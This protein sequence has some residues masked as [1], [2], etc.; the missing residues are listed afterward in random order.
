MKTNKLKLSCLFLLISL[1]FALSNNTTTPSLNQF[2]EIS[3]SAFDVMVHAFDQLV[4]L[5][6]DGH[7]DTEVN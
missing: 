2:V 4:V 1:T 5:F 6:H 7:N 3:P